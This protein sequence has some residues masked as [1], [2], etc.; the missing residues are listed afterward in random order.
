MMMTMHMSHSTFP[1]RPDLDRDLDPGRPDTDRSAAA[2]GQRNKR[3]R[4]ST[5]PSSSSSVASSSSSSAAAAA[6]A[7]GLCDDALQ[8]S[9][10]VDHSTPPRGPFAKLKVG[11]LL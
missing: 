10:R 5:E 6:A 1:H 7:A 8:S 3:L 9:G 11:C 2:D 4:C